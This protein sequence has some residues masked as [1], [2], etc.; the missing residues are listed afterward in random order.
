MKRLLYTLPVLLIVI[1]FVKGCN[2]ENPLVTNPQ[3]IDIEGVKDAPVD[4]IMG[5]ISYTKSYETPLITSNNLVIGYLKVWLDTNKF[6]F[7]FTTT[8]LYYMKNIHLSVTQQRNK[9]PLTG[10]CP[11][12]EA[13][14]HQVHNLAGNT[15]LYT[16]QIPTTTFYLNDNTLYLSS[17]IDYENVSLG[18]DCLYAWAKGAP[19]PNCTEFAK[20]FGLKFHF[21][22][23]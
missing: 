8:T 19:F 20:Y 4:T 7:M 5:N 10:N 17:E 23:T 22:K 2:Y 3:S 12:I 21:K 18:P 11:N 9:I 16:F 15:R 13:F 14:N 1:L 6:Y